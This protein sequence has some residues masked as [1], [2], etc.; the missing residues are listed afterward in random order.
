DKGL[1]WV[2]VVVHD[3]TEG[4]FFG[5][6]KTKVDDEIIEDERRL[7]YVAITRVKKHFVIVSSDDIT[8]LSSW[9]QIRKYTYTR[10][11]KC[12]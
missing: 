7:F 11:L 2:F 5:D 12:K 1:E 9:Y 4:G 10:Y 8:R 6:N 3:A